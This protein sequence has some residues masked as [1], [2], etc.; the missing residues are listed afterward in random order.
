M[1]KRLLTDAQFKLEINRCIYCAEKPCMYACPSQCSPADF[2]MAAKKGQPQDF[3]RAASL[4]LS[5]NPLGGV[6]GVVC[7]DTFCMKACTRELLDHPINI[8]AVQ[9]TIIQKAKEF[10]KMPDF[11]APDESDIKVAVVGSGPAGLS[12]AA[13]LAQEGIQVTI[14]DKG[15]KPGGMC[16][17]IP[18]ERLSKSILQSDIDFLFSLGKITFHKNTIVNRPKNL[19]NDFNAVVIATGLDEPFVL[20]IPGKEKTITWEEFLSQ[21]EKYDVRG[22]KVGIIGGGAVALDC[23]IVA[24]QKKAR[25]IDIICLEKPGENNLT[26]EERETMFNS[27]FGVITRTKVKRISEK[28]NKINLSATRVLLPVGKTFNPASME[29]EPGSSYKLT[30]YDVVIFAVGARGSITNEKVQGMFFCGDVKNGP[31]TVIEAV[32]SGKNTALKVINYLSKT[33]KPII[34]N[35]K[36]SSVKISGAVTTPVSI[37]AEFFG[38]KILS[39]FL[40]SAAPPSDGYEQMK[41]AYESGWAGGIMKTAF[42]NVPIHIPSEY[43]YVLDDQTFGNADN[44]SGHSLN[45]VCD[46]VKKLVEEFPDRLTI[47]STGGPV[48]GNDEADKNV[49]QSNTKKL[50]DAGAMAVEYSLSCPQGGDGTK[51]DI[52]SQDEQLTAKIVDWIME[53]SNPEIPKLFKL[54]GAVTAIYPILA[55]IKNVLKKYPDKKAGVTLANT[56]PGLEF[57][58]SKDKKWDEGVVIGMSGQGVTNISNLTLANASRIDITVSGNGGPMDYKSAADFLALGAETVQFCSI[59]MKY[60]YGIIDELHSGLSYLMAEKNIFSVR[61]LIGSALPNPI[62]GFMELSPI[63]KISD[64]NDELCVKCGNC[65]RCPYLAITLNEN[66]NP[67][68]DASKCIGCSFCVQNCIS[69][70]LFM[71]DR[72]KEESLQLTEH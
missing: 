34:E 10:D 59:V 35:P 8:P 12:A 6:C 61:E 14:Y 45:R 49:W 11:I 23:A 33:E 3:K 52:V 2:I 5:K 20:D 15:D 53:I 65:T 41:K 50:E 55:A 21:I 7:P 69:G 40:L 46:E 19:L 22:K 47:A 16:N 58:K 36:S 24:R 72:T 32:A 9:A 54:T 70:A 39:P 67:R 62:R 26:R 30:N 57:Q 18:D 17:L 4:I 64:V 28:E 60:G 13:V 38:R 25:D 27:G 63:K 43:M 42:D 37:E 48:T 51:G 1:K 71:R 31:T 66:K 68:T 29:E 44:V 56:F